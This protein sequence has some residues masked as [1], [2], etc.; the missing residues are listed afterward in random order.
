MLRLRLTHDPL[1]ISRAHT[2][3]HKRFLSIALFLSL[4]LPPS[5]PPFLHWREGGGGRRREGGGEGGGEGGREGA[6]LSCCSM[7][8]CRA[9]NCPGPGP[10]LKAPHDTGVPGPASRAGF[11]GRL[12]P[13]SCPSFRHHQPVTLPMAPLPGLDESEP[14]LS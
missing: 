8:V 5:L 2:R 6:T 7:S 14:G 4:P 3:T 11:S 9:R 1:S 13:A 12:P 10:P